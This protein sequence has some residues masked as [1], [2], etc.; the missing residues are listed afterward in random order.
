MEISVAITGDLQKAIEYCKKTLKIAMEI[1]DQAGEGRAHHNIGN[2]YAALGQFDIGVGNFV[3]AVDVCNTLRSLLKSEGNWKMKFRDLHEVAYTFLWRSLL[4]T[5]KI[6]EA[7][8]AADQE[9]AQTLNDNLLTQYGLPSPS[10]CA[11]FDSNESRTP[12]F[13]ELSSQIVFIGSPRT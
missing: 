6:N 1:G 12:L 2:G 13:T 9:R 8:V 5:G 10:S 11:T 7:L 3:S 4:R